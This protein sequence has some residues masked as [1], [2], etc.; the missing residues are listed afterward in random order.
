M[1][2]TSVEASD[3]GG[4]KD[5]PRK[6]LEKSHTVYT[7]VKRKINTITTGLNIPEFQESPQAM[8]VDDL[9]EE[10][11][12]SAQRLLETIEIVEAIITQEPKIFEEEYVTL[13]HAT[14]NR[15]SQKML[16]K[17][18]N[19]RNKKSSEKWKSSIDFDGVAPYKIAQFHNATG[20]A[21][22]Q[23]V[24]TMEKENS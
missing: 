3:D 7:S 24:D 16:M 13:H 18:V 1:G 15:E 22:K 21:L 9:I 2:K 6:D 10:L 20:E 5:P 4:D 17:K 12:W 14:Y 8:D 11:S 23:Y 19:T